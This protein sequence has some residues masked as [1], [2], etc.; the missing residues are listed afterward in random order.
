MF[1]ASRAALSA[2]IARAP[3]SVVIACC[4][5]SMMRT[6]VRSIVSDKAFRAR[7]KDTST[8]LPSV[9][10]RDTVTIPAADTVSIRPNTSVSFATA[11]RSSATE[12]PIASTMA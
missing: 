5:S 6:M 2:N 7:V 10:R 8:T 3:A 1:K 12:A 9:R 4:A 11:R